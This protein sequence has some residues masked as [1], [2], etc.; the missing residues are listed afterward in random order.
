LK[1]AKFKLAK[2]GKNQQNLPTLLEGHNL[3][4]PVVPNQHF[5]GTRDAAILHFIKFISQFRGALKCSNKQVRVPRDKKR[6]GTT[7][8]PTYQERSWVRKFATL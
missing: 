4:R 7:A 8:L 5:E 2:I 1:Q 6:L 3:S